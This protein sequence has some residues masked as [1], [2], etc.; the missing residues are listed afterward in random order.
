MDTPCVFV[1]FYRQVAKWNLGKLFKDKSAT[2]TGT[3]SI[4]GPKPEESPPV[5]IS[6]KVWYCSWLTLIS[7][8]YDAL[9]S[10]TSFCA[11]SGYPE[12]MTDPSLSL[13]TPLLQV[14][15]ASVSGL[16]ITSLQVFNEKYRPYKGVRTMTKSGKNFQVRTG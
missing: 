4:Q 1:D 16:S 2:M 11:A 14:P 12:S 8:R 7:Y 13:F 15:M 9:V 10:G 5:Q 6:W 3:M